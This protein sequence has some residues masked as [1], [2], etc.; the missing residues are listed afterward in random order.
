MTSVAS[1]A[2]PSS[3]LGA[4]CTGRPAE[5]VVWTAAPAAAQGVEPRRGPLGVGS[6]P[7][8][9]AIGEP[10]DDCSPQRGTAASAADTCNGVMVPAS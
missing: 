7:A 6:S 4:C 3:P 1:A 8:A 5:S 9:S 10:A 2:G